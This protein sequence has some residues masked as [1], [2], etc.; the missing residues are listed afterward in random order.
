VRR[1]LC[2]PRPRREGDRLQAR[3]RALAGRTKTI[4]LACERGR[5][6]QT[7]RFTWWAGLRGVNRARS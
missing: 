6:K 7:R 4:A 5:E 1:P 2:D 3:T